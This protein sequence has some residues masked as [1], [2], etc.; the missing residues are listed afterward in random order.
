MKYS[1]STKNNDAISK[2]DEIELK[3]FFNRIIRKKLV[4]GYTT[5]F[6]L[7]ISIISF[8]L[9]E[10][11]WEG[12][13]QIVLASQ[14]KNLLGG[15]LP[16]P[17]VLPSKL[18]SL[19]GP[20]PLETE[21]GILE[22]PS[23]L[24][25]IFD[26]VKKEKIKNNRKYEK[27]TFEKWKE[28]LQIELKKNTSILNIS[29]IDKDKDLNL[30]VLEKISKKF[31]DYSGKSQRRT[32]ALTKSYLNEQIGIYKVKSSESIKKAQQFAMSE[33]LVINNSRELGS[34]LSFNSIDNEKNNDMVSSPLNNIFY[35]NV[36]IEAIRA[37]AANQIRMIDRKLEKI[38]NLKDDYE[39]LVFFSSTIPNLSKKDSLLKE[40]SL[41]EQE[42]IAL[43]IKYTDKDR[44]II[45]LFE[46]KK[47][48]MNA[49]KEKAI[50]YLKAER[51]ATE[52]EMESAIRP[53]GILLK[54]KELMREAARDEITLINLENQ[55]RAIKLREAKSEDPWELI[56]KP[57]LIDDPI[58]PD[59]KINLFFGLLAGLISGSLLIKN[60][61]KKSGLVFEKE[62]ILNDLKSPLLI[63]NAL[64]K[65]NKIYVNSPFI[66][67]LIRD[68]INIFFLKIN[69]ISNDGIDI[70]KKELEKINFKE[71]R[72][73]YKILNDNFKEINEEDVLFLI[74]DVKS[75]TYLQ[76]NEY[77]QR[78][79]LY[80]IKSDGIFFI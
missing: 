21:V 11:S 24:M 78:L 54:Y 56:T 60:I 48:L 71:S 73:K 20:K 66:N 10:K 33:D 70:I 30:L 26:Y 43:R 61:E 55:L 38:T 3:Y 4:L 77:V 74:I 40:L 58:Y 13:F 1:Q 76:L 36:Q 39:Q 80:K 16:M 75:L 79:N 53:E 45:N 46:R 47:I 65:E 17:N 31:Q 29:Y 18:I 9:T 72:R 34:S 49:I 37:A 41:I 57:T 67:D 25:G 7:L 6:T 27:I 2:D 69:D 59:L 35:G 15:K 28:N 8:L 23:V 63:D 14:E 5:A 50:G 19:Q 68:K 22:S 42:L 64:E 51:L 52:A 12:S 32:I 62:I 44:N